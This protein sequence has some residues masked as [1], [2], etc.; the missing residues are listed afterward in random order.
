MSIEYRGDGKYRFRVRKAGVNYT[1][2][3]F[4]YKKLSEKDIED[5]KYPKEVNDAHKKFEVDVMSGKIGSNENIKF[6][7]LAQMVYDEYVMVNCKVRTQSLYKQNY[8]NYILPAFGEMKTSAITTYHIQKFMNE[9]SKKLSPGSMKFIHVVLNK[10]FALSIKWGFI[11]DNPMIGV[12]RI[13]IEKKN[14]DE[15]LSHDDMKRLFTAI[16][17]EKNIMHKTAYELALGC[18]LRLSEIRALTIDDIDFKN[19]TINIDKQIGEIRDKDGKIIQGVTPPKTETSNRK[20]YAPDFVME[21]LR[22]HI[23]SMSYIPITKQ[24]FW[25]HKTQKPLSR[26]PLPL[27]FKRLLKK[28]NL[29]DIRFHDL[30]HLQA[31]LLIHAGTNPAVVSKRL[32]HSSIAITL[33]TYTHSI[34]EFDKQSATNFDRIIKDIQAN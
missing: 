29:P 12:E 30:R 10:T 18:G 31:T 4:C 2:N 20:I 16:E 3:Y 8:N 22:K 1:Q 5:K 15:L 19:G 32:G 33:D 27:A 26:S 13:K 11:K 28:N 21:T 7:E 34:E 23:D 17:N 25:S 24:I 6:G 9:T 14:F